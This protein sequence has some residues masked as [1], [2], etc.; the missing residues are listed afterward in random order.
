MSIVRNSCQFLRLA[1]VSAILALIINT[2]ASAATIGFDGLSSGLIP[3][4]VTEEGFTYSQ[5]SGYLYVH[6]TWGN[7]A[8]EIQGVFAQGGGT[9]KIVSAIMNQ[10]FQFLGM[11]I[12]YYLN[13]AVPT[14][15]P[16]SRWSFTVSGFFEGAL[17]ATENLKNTETTAFHFDGYSTVGPSAGLLGA[18]IDEL[19]ISLPA[20]LVQYEGNDY[21]Y[22]GRLDNVQLNPVPEPA[23]MLLLASGL[24]GLAG[25]RRRFKKS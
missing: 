5:S 10:P 20:G 18:M 25:L 3:G 14:P 17:V 2:N 12:C 1:F 7:P 21:A 8:P 15:E 16:E 19:Y 6:E 13:S 11:D 22:Y 9:L 24:V 23:T 4:T